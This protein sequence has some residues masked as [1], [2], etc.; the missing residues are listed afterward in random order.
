MLSTSG[1]WHEFPTRGSSRLGHLFQG[2]EKRLK[3]WQCDFTGVIR[4]ARNRP[5][6][7]SMFGS[8]SIATVKHTYRSISGPNFPDHLAKQTKE[9]SSSHEPSTGTVESP[10]R[11]NRSQ[12]GFFCLCPRAARSATYRS[13]RTSASKKPRHLAIRPGCWPILVLGGNIGVLLGPPSGSLCAIDI[14]FDNQIDPLSDLQSPVAR[15]PPYS[16]CKRL[17]DLWFR[18]RQLSTNELLRAA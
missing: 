9:R 14:D 11:V 3:T 16:W 8:E 7:G 13:G 17:P 6:F 2:G 15:E 1:R 10:L 18:Q 12:C 4:A 5:F